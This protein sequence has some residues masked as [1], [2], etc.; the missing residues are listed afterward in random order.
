MVPVAGTY[1]LNRGAVNVVRYGPCYTRA[2]DILARLV[3]STRTWVLRPCPTQHA[4]LAKSCLGA[5]NRQ[6]FKFQEHPNQTRDS[7]LTYG[8]LHVKLVQTNAG[9]NLTRL[10]RIRSF[11]LRLGG[12]DAYEINVDQ[13][14]R[15][16]PLGRSLQC[17][18]HPT[19]YCIKPSTLEAHT[20]AGVPATS[21]NVLIWLRYPAPDIGHRI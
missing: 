13:G 6:A 2:A 14:T 11:K 3:N 12:S 7:S 15:A 17:V 8:S 9:L 1:Y 20:D 21:K 4:P 5:G 16:C 19:C 18:A 10:Y